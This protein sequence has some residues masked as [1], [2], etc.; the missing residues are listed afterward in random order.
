MKTLRKLFYVACTMFFLASCEETYDKLFS[1]GRTQSGIWLV[2]Q[3]IHSGPDL[4]RRKVNRK[5]RQLSD[6]R[7]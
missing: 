6:G 7:Q 3:T 4:Q 1:A 2:Y 5:N